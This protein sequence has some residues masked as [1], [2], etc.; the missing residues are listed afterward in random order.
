MTSK[1]LLF[2]GFLAASSQTLAATIAGVEVPTPL[3]QRNVSDTH[4]GVSVDDPYR[5]FEDAKEPAVAAWMKA[6]AEAT[7]A[8]LA[9]IP[10]R[11]DLLARIKEIESKASGQT[12]RAVRVASGRYFFL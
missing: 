9:R 8:I 10:G 1:Q 5:Y 11:D 7:T 3:P 4:F 12:D 6:N 2:I